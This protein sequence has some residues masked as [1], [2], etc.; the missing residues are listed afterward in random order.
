[1]GA[2][3]CGQISLGHKLGDDGRVIRVGISVDCVEESV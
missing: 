3:I 2:V 1:L